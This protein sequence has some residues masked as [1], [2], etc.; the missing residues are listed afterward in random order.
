[1]QALVCETIEW[2]ARPD[3]W[4]LQ[5][6]KRRPVSSDRLLERVLA[7]LAKTE[8]RA[9]RSQAESIVR[10]IAQCLVSV[11]ARSLPPFSF[12]RGDDGSVAIEWRFPDRRLA[13]TIEADERES[14]WHIVFSQSAGGAHAYGPLSNREMRGQV[15]QALRL[16]Q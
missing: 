6:P 8:N 1:M 3:G 4:R 7:S 14:G 15:A 13:F 16:A 2:S 12:A 9:I 11:D 10:E 5:I